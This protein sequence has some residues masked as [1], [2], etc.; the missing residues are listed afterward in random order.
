M[1][2]K[3]KVGDIITNIEGE[4]DAMFDLLREMNDFVCNFSDMSTDQKIERLN[5][6]GD[7]FKNIG[8]MFKLAKDEGLDDVKFKS[9]VVDTDGRTT[10][11]V[12]TDEDETTR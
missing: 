9:K 3:H 1:K 2:R 11:Q 5:Y 4:Q 7:T 10:M 8:Y 12:M 6:F